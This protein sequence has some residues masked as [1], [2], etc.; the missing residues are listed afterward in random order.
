M[1]KAIVVGGGLAGPV[2]AMALHRAGIDATVY[3]AYERDAVG[4]GAFL[5]LSVNGVD[6]L[7][8]VG[9][10]GLVGGLG[11]PTPRMALHNHH[12]R[13]LGEFGTSGTRTRGAGSS[14]V[15]RSDLYRA[16]RDE[17]VRRG[18][19]IVP[20][21]RL[22]DAEASGT[23]VLARFA[24]GRTVEGDLLI[25]ADGLRSRV[26]TLIDPAAPAPRYV[27]LLNAGG[28]ARGLRLSDERGVMHMLFGRRCFFCWMVVGDDEVWW[29]ANPPQPTEPTR[30]QLAA[31]GHDEARARLRT[32]LAGDAGPA[33]AVLDHTER[34]EY[35][36]P[37]YD[38]PS[39]PVWHRDRMIVIGDAAHT[40]APSSGQ[41]AA[42]AFEDGVQLARC[43]R[44]LP[45]VPAAFAAYEKLRRRRVERVVA[46]GK[47]VS[48]SKVPGPVGRLAR[49][50]AM[51]IFARL[52]ARNDGAAL[53]WLYDHHID[54][55]A[56][57]KA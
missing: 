49:D 36:W 30:E 33:L 18:V 17:T 35:G 25:G 28:F 29:F 52:T 23:G 12:G 1:T 43:L 6:A 26:R 21:A 40:A 50:L 38:L 13:E 55:A 20:G 44:D 37:T 3:E 27:P 57:V 51:P 7:R 34:I 45:D 53:A 22:V 48:G 47:R 16:L 54:W 11:H 42:M 39:V 24:D 15:R 9:V 56:P 31:I 10:D 46:Q 4:V 19:A 32:L 41:G 8:A 5:T 2:A 14:T